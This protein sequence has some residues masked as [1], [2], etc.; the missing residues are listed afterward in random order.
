MVEHHEQDLRLE[1]EGNDTNQRQ[2]STYIK[3]ITAE[4]GV[5][6]QRNATMIDSLRM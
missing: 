6:G 4:V 2:T 1:Q 5:V 3:P